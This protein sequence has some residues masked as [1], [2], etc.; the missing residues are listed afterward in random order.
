MYCFARSNEDGDNRSVQPEINEL[1][2]SAV[3]AA[4]AR[5]VEIVPKL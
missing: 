1:L 4:L 5:T 3:R 2:S